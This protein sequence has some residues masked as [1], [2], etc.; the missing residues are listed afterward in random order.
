LNGAGLR[1]FAEKLAGAGGWAVSH[2]V[3]AAW[4]PCTKQ[5]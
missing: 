2:F 4:P 5:R 3:Y 1:R